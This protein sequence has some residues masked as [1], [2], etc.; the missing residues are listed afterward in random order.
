MELVQAVPRRLRKVQERFVEGNRVTLLRD[1][2]QA[3]PAMLEAIAGARRQV[4]LEM[5]WFD[6]DRAGRR[7]TK[8]LLE[9]RGRGLEVALI[10]D[11]LGSWE[12]DPA[13]FSELKQAGVHVIEFNPMM[14]WKRRF[15]LAR[16]SLRDH[17]KILVVDGEKGFTGGVNLADV[18]LPEEEEG[19]GWRDDMICVQGPAVGGLMNLFQRT[20]R[21]EGGA[22]LTALPRVSGS[23]RLGDQRVQ[24]LG[25]HYALRRREITSAY[26]LNIYR[27]RSRVWIT[28]SYFVPDPTVTRALK[29]AARRGVD[30]RVILP[31]FSDV[32]IVRHASRAMWG[33][34]LR[35]GVRIFE[36][37]RSILHSKSAVIDGTWSTIGS[38][39][40]DYRSLRANLEVN[41]AVQ[42]TGF[43]TVMEESFRRDLEHCREVDA[44]EFKFRPLG[45]RLLETILYR[46]RKF[47]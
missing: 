18:W 44:H 20:W 32:E 31:A 43:G 3:F 19:Q 33:G 46:F 9:A 36:F 42:D 29:R 47:L 15:R 5:Y 11:S 30:V 25:E 22:P 2:V 27:A 17:R 21:R 38:F 24:V 34:L 28:N 10:Y 41:V 16:L 26:L 37:Y 35:S 4:L 14:P 6:S 40:M 12:A 23:G 8:A 7:F 45:N 39:N 1:A 13:M